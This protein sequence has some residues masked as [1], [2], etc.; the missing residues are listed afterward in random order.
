MKL[1]K[2]RWKKKKKN[3]REFSIIGIAMN[4]RPNRIVEKSWEKSG[5]R[6]EVGQTEREKKKGWR[7]RERERE[8]YSNIG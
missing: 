4:D 1:D 3:S 8:K 7:E 2:V 5:K 6:K